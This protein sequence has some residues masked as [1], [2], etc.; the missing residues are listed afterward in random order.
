MFVPRS[1]KK[2]KNINSKSHLNTESIFREE[3]KSEK[4]I[5]IADKIINKEVQN[6]E[7]SNDNEKQPQESVPVID[8]NQESDEVSAYEKEK[9]LRE[10]LLQKFKKPKLVENTVEPPKPNEHLQL[11]PSEMIAERYQVISQLGKGVFAT[12]YRCLD[13]FPE[14]DPADVAIKVSSISRS[15]P[16]TISLI[17]LLLAGVTQD[18]TDD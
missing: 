11:E 13:T 5:P 12:V 3:G 2:A 6:E 14:A 18:R 17:P 8:T 15:P 10:K 7:H 9:L 16:L 1:L 4:I